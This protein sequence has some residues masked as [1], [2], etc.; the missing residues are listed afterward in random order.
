MRVGLCT[1]NATV[2]DVE[3][4][5]SKILQA[6]HQALEAGADL[7]LF[8]ELMLPGYPPLDLLERPSFIEACLSSEQK[9]IEALPPGLTVIFGNV[10]RTNP[11]LPGRALQNVAVVAQKGRK[12]LSV[13]KTLLPTYDV[14]DEARYF[15]PRK[16]EPALFRLHDRLIGVTI[17]EDMWNDPILWKTEDLWRDDSPHPKR[18]YE[19]DP[20]A[21]LKAQG[22]NLLVNLSASPWS[23]GKL[24]V[25]EK[26]VSH[27]ARRHEID[28]VY[29]NAVGGNDGLIFDGHPLAARS[30]GTWLARS[31]GW[32]EGVQVTS[33]N[34][35]PVPALSRPSEIEDIRSALVLGIRDYFG[36]TGIQKA[37]VGLS[38]GIDSALTAA[39]AVRALSKDK[40]V[41]VSM[42]SAISSEHS[43][44]DARRLASNLGI[45]FHIIPI[46]DIVSGF[47]G[48]LAAPF[49][50]REPDV[51]EENLQSR[52]RG[53]LLMAMANKFGGVVLGTGNKSEAAM[54]YA[55]LYGDTIGAIS[56]LADLYKG[57]VY[58][59][60]RL[61]N[62][63]VEVIP[64]RTLEKPPSAELR[65]N[66]KDSD[67]LPD[68][69]LLD[70]VLERFI[71]HRMSAEQIALEVDAPKALVRELL[72]KVYFNEFKRKQM[73]PT[74]RV[75]RKAWV[76]RVYPIV[77]RFRA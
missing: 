38:G 8:P 45:D 42:P 20:V 31:P 52:I 29:V 35:E 62:Q 15:E 47:G 19:R 26:I 75:C 73:P 39:L 59:L 69:P 33:L 67:S 30:D 76:G 64:T 11:G 18:V 32:T 37:F 70:A 41:G 1:L 48:A 34:E 71:E 5:A 72:S 51:T 4:N 16:D 13:P 7:A 54:G 68:Y 12:T 36:K 53:T 55:T 58:A 49:A 6:A 56:V 74:L 24:E 50:G 44:E 25:R 60:A 66:Q 65:P 63:N 43:I 3:G 10:G 2:G 40:V 17:C 77:Q 28:V 23:R 61:E 9:L 21:E 27:A 57:Q 46:A 22:A 14:F